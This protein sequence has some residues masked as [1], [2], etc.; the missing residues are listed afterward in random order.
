MARCRNYRRAILRISWRR[1]PRLK[2]RRFE[3]GRKR[4]AAIFFPTFCDFSRWRLV[5]NYYVGVRF[6]IQKP[7]LQETRHG[8]ETYD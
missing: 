2:P 3:I 8:E 4:W 7:I 5:L 6:P 1:K